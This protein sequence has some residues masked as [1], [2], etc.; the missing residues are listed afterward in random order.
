[1]GRKTG[2]GLLVL[3][4]LMAMGFVRS[5]ASILAPATLVAF[6]IPVVLPAIGGA[7]L[8][9]GGG[10]RRADRMQ[11]LRQRTIEA[12]ILRLATKEGGRLTAGDVA[13][14]LA[15]SPEEAKETLDA[16]MTRDLADIAVSDD[17]VLVYLFHESGK[18]GSKASARGILDD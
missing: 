9:W 14:A 2:V 15:L 4:A 10:R 13:I 7:T 5:T 12:E 16:L 18:L 1:M 8:L 11:T 3:A 6:L 17:G